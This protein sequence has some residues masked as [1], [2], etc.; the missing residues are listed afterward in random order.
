MDAKSSHLI[1]KNKDTAQCKE[2]KMYWTGTG[3]SDIYWQSK[4][5][6]LNSH[7]KCFNP[8]FIH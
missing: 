4:I 1:L 3:Y 7:L 8:D 6:W 2:L 5:K